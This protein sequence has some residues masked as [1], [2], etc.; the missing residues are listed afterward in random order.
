MGHMQAGESCTAAEVRDSAR[1]RAGRERRG[2]SPALFSGRY[3][4]LFPAQEREVKSS[5]QSLSKCR[6]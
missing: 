2:T 3:L 5:K 6:Q 1:G 4:P